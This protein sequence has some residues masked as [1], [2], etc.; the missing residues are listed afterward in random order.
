MLEKD[1]AQRRLKVLVIAAA[2]HPEK[3]SEPGL[4]WG[5][6][7]ALSKYHNLWV[8]TGE[9]EGNRE[10]IERRFDEVP[11]LRTRL[12]VYFIPRPDGPRI[13]TI[14]PLLYYRCYRMHLNAYHWPLTCMVPYILIC[15][16][17]E[18]DRLQSPISLKFELPLCGWSRHSE[19]ALRFASVLINNFSI[20]PLKSR[21]TNYN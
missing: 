18:H 10:A 19:C 4:G 15:T 11:D 20:M 21:L 3:G 2:V 9:R 17:V 14:I 5:W 1:I 8:I 13:E 16:S 7:E 12:K 6:V